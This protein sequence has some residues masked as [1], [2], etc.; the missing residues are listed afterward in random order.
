MFYVLN[1]KLYNHNY[2]HI[3]LNELINSLIIK[4]K[5]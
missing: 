1:V 2:F 3:T 5:N 4:I